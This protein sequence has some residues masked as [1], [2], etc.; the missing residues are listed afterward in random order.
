MDFIEPPL[1]RLQESV[2][3]FVAPSCDLCDVCAI[4][5]QI[6][7]RQRALMDIEVIRCRLRPFIR[8]EGVRLHRRLQ[9]RYGRRP[10]SGAHI[11]CRSRLPV[12]MTP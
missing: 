4:K 7:L 8:R 9:N 11:Q 1:A 10:P 5:A 12:I 6:E 2:S 3:R